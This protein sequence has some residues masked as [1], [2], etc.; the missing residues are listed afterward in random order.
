MDDGQKV[1]VLGLVLMLVLMPVL[2]VGIG[3]GSIN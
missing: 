3:A 1:L 2:D